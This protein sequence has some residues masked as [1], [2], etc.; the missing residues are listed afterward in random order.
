MRRCGFA[1]VEI[2]V[3]IAIIALLAAAYVGFAGGKGKQKSIPKRAIEKAESVECR[4]NLNQIRQMIQMESADTGA[5]P[6]RIDQGATATI[7]RCPVGG[8]AYGY[9]PRTGR[10]WCTTPGHERY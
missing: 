3:V 2:L 9:D 5:W 4:S 8:Q 1:L 6:A 10:V 7:S